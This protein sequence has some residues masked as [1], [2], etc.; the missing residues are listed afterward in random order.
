ML[1]RR[2]DAASDL[3]RVADFY[4]ETSDYWELVEG[5]TARLEKAEE[6]FK[7]APPNRSSEEGFRL[8]VF[9]DGR[10]SGIADMFLDYPEPRE[11]YIGLMVLGAWSRNKGI[12]RRFLNHLEELARAGKAARL[13]VGV[14]T[15][16]PRGR[17][18]WEREGFSPTGRSTMYTVGGIRREMHRLVKHL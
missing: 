4:S 16:N 2:L 6:F 5:T 11:A 15:I 1:I 14:M 17:A 10:L 3:N 12:G 13:Y 9:L 7:D 18:F 8:G